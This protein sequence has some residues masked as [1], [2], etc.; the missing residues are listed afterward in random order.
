MRMYNFPPICTAKGSSAYDNPTFT[1]PKRLLSIHIE[2]WSRDSHGT[3]GGYI[4]K[5]TRVLTKWDQIYRSAT[6]RGSH[7]EW[8]PGERRRGRIA[9]R[10][11]VL[12]WG[13]QVPW[14]STIHRLHPITQ[15]LIPILVA[16]S[17]FLRGPCPAPGAV[18]EARSEG[19]EKLP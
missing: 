9:S 4:H 3:R 15:A 6:K 8:G 2:S 13:D 11:Y 17:L 12:K 7:E 14:V 19:R 5:K 16:R 10:V 18:Q 1:Q